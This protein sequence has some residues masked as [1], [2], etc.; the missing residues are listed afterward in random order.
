MSVLTMYMHIVYY[1]VVIK[2]NFNDCANAMLMC[3]ILVK[4]KWI[5]SLLARVFW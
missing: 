4:S 2:L 5:R 1:F 3:N